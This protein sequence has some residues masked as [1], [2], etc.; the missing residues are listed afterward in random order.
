MN[1]NKLSKIFAKQYHSEMVGFETTTL[2][3]SLSASLYNVARGDELIHET[4][5]DL[6]TRTLA[7]AGLLNW[8]YLH[9][10]VT[11]KKS[12]VTVS[13]C[14]QS[15]ILLGQILAAY[16]NSKTEAVNTWYTELL[17][18]IL[19]S[20]AYCRKVWLRRSDSIKDETLRQ[21]L[22]NELQYIR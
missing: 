7:V 14:I 10:E 18:E 5:L 9:G 22:V 12:T 6:V 1:F 20:T 13:N 17:N 11:S 4:Q 21:E 3:F 19:F 8:T 16:R 2:I 15:S